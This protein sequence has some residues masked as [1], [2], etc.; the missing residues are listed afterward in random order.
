MAQ[1]FPLGWARLFA[2]TA[3]GPLRIQQQGL[4]CCLQPKGIGWLISSTSC[5]LW[6][7]LL[8]SVSHREENS[9][10]RT[11]CTLCVRKEVRSDVVSSKLCKEKCLGVVAVDTAC[12]K[13]LS[14]GG[15]LASFPSDLTP[16]ME[17]FFF[18]SWDGARQ[19]VTST[20]LLRHILWCITSS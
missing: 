9:I 18:A 10:S 20:R 14:L 5:T 6:D 12:A 11:S 7:K 19:M 4:Q 8:C 1:M 15:N 16:L 2:L 13:Q 17:I 3:D